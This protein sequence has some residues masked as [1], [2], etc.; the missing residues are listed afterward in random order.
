LPAAKV[1]VLAFTVRVAGAVV[2]DAPTVSH[3]SFDV[4]VNGTAFPFPIIETITDCPAGV[5]D[6]PVEPV[7]VRFMLDSCS[8]G[9]VVTTKTTGKDV[10]VACPD[11]ATC[12]VVV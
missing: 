8:T 5:C 9:F 11:R 3:G 2:A 10:T 7:K 4:A 1:A 12:T 6:D